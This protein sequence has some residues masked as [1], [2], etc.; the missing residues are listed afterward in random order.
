MAKSWGVAVQRYAHERFMNSYF[1]WENNTIFEPLID[2]LL[3]Y[4]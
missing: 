4:W 2:S 1:G 3:M